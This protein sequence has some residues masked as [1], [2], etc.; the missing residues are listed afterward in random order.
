[1]NESISSNFLEACGDQ[2]VADWRPMTEDTATQYFQELHPGVIPVDEVFSV[3]EA[4]ELLKVTER[5]LLDAARRGQVPGRKVGRSWR[6]SKQKL[7]SWLRQDAGD[8]AHR[9]EVNMNGQDQSPATERNLVRGLHVPRQER[10]RPK[11]APFDW[12]RKEPETGSGTGA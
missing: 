9:K 5:A 7:L 10:K 3:A 12:S 6:F 2:P 11:V 1:M 8:H 4:A